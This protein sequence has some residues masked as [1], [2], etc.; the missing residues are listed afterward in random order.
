MG[1]PELATVYMKDLKT[2]YSDS[3]EGNFYGEDKNNITTTGPISSV[4]SGRGAG[5]GKDLV[6]VAE[7]HDEKK[8]DEISVGKKKKTG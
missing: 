1:P 8:V 3:F 6:S 4:R 5:V 2:R 7:L